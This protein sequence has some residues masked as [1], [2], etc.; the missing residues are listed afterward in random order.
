M[1]RLSDIKAPEL[2]QDLAEKMLTNVLGNCQL[3]PNTVP[4]N[5]L[6]SYS[7]YRRERY[8][9]Q[10]VIIL[11]LLAVFL[12]LPVF[13][14]YPDFDIREKNRETP[15]EDPAYELRIS[16]AMP[17]SLVSA[18][19]DGRKVAVY[20]NESH[21]YTME[22]TVNGTMKVRVTLLNRQWVEQEIEV[23]GIDRESPQLLDSSSDGEMLTLLVKDDGLGIDY[24]E[25]YSQG[26]SGTVYKP[27]SVQEEKGE[28]LFEIPPESVTIY[29]PDIRDNLLKLAVTVT[30]K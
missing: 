7:E 2:T 20:E 15:E 19:I 21:V 5:K 13:F 14:I 18:F 3:E 11:V 9:F 29:I 23:T 4:L 24:D 16:N 26:D 17:V 8:S 30:N 22:P 10:K 25:I 6:E 27:V 12:F 28:I 1:N